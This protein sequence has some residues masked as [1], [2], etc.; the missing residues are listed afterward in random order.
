MATICG[1]AALAILAPLLPGLSWRADDPALRTRR[2]LAHTA[3]VLLAILPLLAAVLGR[4]VLSTAI[5]S[6][7]Q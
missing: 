5:R 2:L 3:A 6:L 1:L 4:G 7:V